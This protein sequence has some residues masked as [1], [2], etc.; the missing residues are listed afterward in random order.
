MKTAQIHELAARFAALQD[1]FVY[2]TGLIAQRDAELDA[3]EADV[4]QLKDA[5]IS[6]LKTALSDKLSDAATLKLA[7]QAAQMEHAE[8]VR[9]MRLEHEV[10]ELEQREEQLRTQAS[11][12]D[13]ERTEWSL[14]LRAAKQELETQRS[15]LATQMEAFKR[16]QEAEIRMHKRGV[17]TLAIEAEHRV[18]QRDA[19]IAALQAARDTLQNAL[20]EQ[21]AANRVLETTLRDLRWQM[22]D[23]NRMTAARITE[24]EQVIQQGDAQAASDAA[25]FEASLAR[26]QQEK[27]HQTNVLKSERDALASQ[28]AMLR[29]KCADSEARA[30]SAAARHMA[31]IMTL[32]DQLHAGEAKIAELEHD[33][34]KSRASLEETKRA[35]DAQLAARD[36]EA[37][38]MHSKLSR[39][40]SD[41]ADRRKEIIAFKNEISERIEREQLLERQMLEDALNWEQQ[42]EELVRDK[43]H[44]QDGLLKTLM[45]ERQAAQAEIKACA[46]CEIP[47]TFGWRALKAREAALADAARAGTARMNPDRAEQDHREQLDALASENAQLREVIREMRIEMESLHQQMSLAVPRRDPS[48]LAHHDLLPPSRDPLLADVQVE[49]GRAPASPPRPTQQADHRDSQHPTDGQHAIPRQRPGQAWPQQSEQWTQPRQQPFHQQEGHAAAATVAAETEDVLALESENALLRDKLAQAVSDLRRI[50][51]DKARFVDM[52][53]T[54]RA[55]LR[56]IESKT[57]STADASTQTALSALAASLRPTPVAAAQPSQQQ[58]QQSRPPGPPRPTVVQSRVIP[59]TQSERETAGQ[60]QMRARSA[61]GPPSPTRQAGIAPGAPPRQLTEAEKA[62]MFRLALRARGVRNW[63]EKDDTS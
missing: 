60:A 34:A 25:K 15:A 6:D 46:Y 35:H 13:H 22:T 16:D 45:S 38:H 54:L 53:N 31:E 3:L 10:R 39:L 27:D 44:E 2:N 63:N 29:A 9:H 11:E 19:E 26:L 56:M 33:V 5:R 43:Q 20:E 40:E 50:A 62:N 51:Q 61:A 24:L 47:R 59:K 58:Q 23:T 7:L 28:V 52:S 21:Q 48:P 18:A 4:L 49:D 8:A 42:Y 37:S 41:L 30:E 17:D 36:A 14:R 57:A 1:D 32:K 12:H 55:E